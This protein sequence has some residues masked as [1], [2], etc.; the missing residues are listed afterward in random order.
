MQARDLAAEAQSRIYPQVTAQASTSDNRESAHH[1]FSNSAVARQEGSNEVGAAASWEP[2]FWGAIR[3]SAR[4]QKRLAQASAA[5]LATARLSLQ[6]ELANDYVALRGLDAEVQVLR[7]SIAAYQKAAEVARLR[8]EGKI[9]SGLD[10]ARALSE[11]D[12]ARAQETETERQ[13]ELLQHAIAVLVGAMPSTFSIAPLDNFMLTPPELPPGVPSALLQRRP[14][15][16]SAERQMAAANA[17]IGVSRAAFHPN[18]TFGTVAGFEDNAFRLADLPNSLWSVGAGVMLPLSEGGLSLT[19][20][21]ATEVVQQREASQEAVRALSISTMLYQDGL[22]S[23]LSVAIAQ[24]RALAAQTAEVQLSSRQM[25]AVVALIR[26]LG[27]GWTMQELPSE[28]Q[29]LPFAPQDYALHGSG[30]PDR[31]SDPAL[32]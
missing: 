8:A 4:G 7:Q 9:A 31:Y 2:D 3:N 5:D 29:T 20:R 15:I 26:A 16:A 19:Q 14:D 10:L 18:V 23:Y 27:G 28:K 1:L 12:S 13:R 22:D 21:L 30:N 25:Q 17:S 11:L 6:A 32:Q 24:V